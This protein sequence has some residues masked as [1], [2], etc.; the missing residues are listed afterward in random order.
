M[1]LATPRTAT[2]KAVHAFLSDRLRGARGIVSRLE[3]LRF[4]PVDRSSPGEA[5]FLVGADEASAELLSACRASLVLVE[6]EMLG[7][8]HQPDTVVLAV[9]RPRREFAR[10][11][12][13][14]FSVERR[15]SGI[16]PSAFVD[17]SARIGQGTQVEAGAYVGPAVI[18]GAECRIGPNATIL[19]G[20]HLADR[21]VVGPGATLGHTGFS[22]ERDIDGTPIPIPHRGGVRVGADVEIGANS[23]IDRGVFDDTVIEDHV[24]LDNLVQV[25][26]NVV[27]RRGAYVIA[28]A[29]LCGGVRIG[30]D[31]W[32]A[33]SAV[34]KEKVLIGADA[35]VG[36]GANVMR[37]VQAG[38]TVTGPPARPALVVRD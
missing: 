13:A 38:A 1:D 36:I 31:S 12:N 15:S 16:H 22:Y 25:G 27:V 14:F 21:V 2:I 9:D 20:C 8:A 28:G 33:P 4:A 29:V 24:K 35:T 37:D 18:V 11:A 26:H 6:P 19:P 30:S 32:I 23:C 3:I 7:G 10:V 5:S 34:I 17:P